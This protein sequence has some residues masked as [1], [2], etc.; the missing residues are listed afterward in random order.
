MV[1]AGHSVVAFDERLKRVSRSVDH[2][3]FAEC[4]Q[5]HVCKIEDCTGG[6]PAQ[7][8]AR[9]GSHLVQ[10]GST[11]SRPLVF[12]RIAVCVDVDVA[13]HVSDDVRNSLS[14]DAF[15]PVVYVLVRGRRPESPVLV[16]CHPE[17]LQELHVS[18]KRTYWAQVAAPLVVLQ[19]VSLDVHHHLKSQRLQWDVVA[20]IAFASGV[21]G[22]KEVKN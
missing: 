1:R 16:V 8:M 21:L 20:P 18:H 3:A 9:K 11:V 19:P 4:Y 10:H 14:S 6:E 12:G 15:G 22:A 2:V 13:Q 17:F 5:F 7:E